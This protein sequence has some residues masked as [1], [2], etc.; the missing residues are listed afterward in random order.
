[1]V[2]GFGLLKLEDLLDTKTT[3]EF[4]AGSS[5]VALHFAIF[6]ATE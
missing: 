3:T 5:D 1:M 2:L 6:A 4:V